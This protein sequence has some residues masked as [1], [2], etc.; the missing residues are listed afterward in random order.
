[1]SQRLFGARSRLDVLAW[2]A[3]LIL[4]VVIAFASA[5]RLVL[6]Q[7]PGFQ[8]LRTFAEIPKQVAPPLVEGTDGGLY[9]TAQAGGEFGRGAILRF[10][11]HAD[12]SLTFAIIHSFSTGESA[13]PSFPLTR[14]SDGQWF[15]VNGLKWDD[16]GGHSIGSLFRVSSTGT[17]EK[18]HEF[19]DAYPCTPLV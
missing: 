11:R 10:D 9:G 12:G 13:H 2:L 8:V 6:A 7:S 18:F 4:G 17:Y 14:A 3:R 1:M 15:G 16:A 19:P 5:P